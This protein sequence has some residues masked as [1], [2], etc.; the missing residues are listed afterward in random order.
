MSLTISKSPTLPLYADNLGI[1]VS[2]IGFIAA[3]FTIVGISTNI[4]AG[5]LSDTW[6][7]I[8]YPLL[9]KLIEWKL[10]LSRHEVLEEIKIAYVTPQRGL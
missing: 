9:T 1:L 8:V 5:I 10:I 4:I 7:N 3:S 2:E 6:R